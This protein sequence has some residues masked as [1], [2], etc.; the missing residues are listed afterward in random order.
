MVHRFFPN[1]MCPLS[2]CCRIL[3]TWLSAYYQG[4]SGSQ[5]II[6]GDLLEAELTASGL[7]AP[8]VQPST[9]LPHEGQAAE[10]SIPS[11]SARFG[12]PTHTDVVCSSVS[13]LVRMAAAALISLYVYLN[14][15]Q[16]PSDLPSD[17]VL[18]VYATIAI[19]S[20]AD[21]ENVAALDQ[22]MQAIIDEDIKQHGQQSVWL[23]QGPQLGLELQQEEAA[24]QGTLQTLQFGCAQVSGF[25]ILRMRLVAQAAGGVV[26]HSWVGGS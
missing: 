18:L 25:C 16:G 8:F 7:V 19:H 6:H 26:A 1:S 23:A 15:K 2:P 10:D 20:C 5:S 4:I 22:Q 24:E 14:F 12:V 13:E 17:E 9:P 11:G 3:L 21:A